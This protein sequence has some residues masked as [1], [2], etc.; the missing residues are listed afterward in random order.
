MARIRTL[1]PEFWADEKLARLSALTRLV[2]VGLISQAD[3]A[4]RLID[5]VKL[6]DGLL[7]PETD[8]T[9]R[10]ALEELAGADRILRYQSEAGQR[11]IQV[12][13]WEKHQKVDK[14]SKY[15][16]PAATET[17]APPPGNDPPPSRDSR[18]TVA[19]SPRSDLGPT[20]PDLR[21]TTSEPPRESAAEAPTPE[22]A[23]PAAAGDDGWRLHR[24]E[25]A[26]F[27]QG[28]GYGPAEL[29][30]AQGEDKSIWQTPTGDLVPWGD[31]LRLLGLADA[32]LKKSGTKA[33]DLRQALKYV[34]LQQ[35]DPIADRTAAEFAANRP[36]PGTEAA[37]VLA[38]TRDRDSGAGR[39]HQPHV[40]TGPQLVQVDPAE[41]GRE[42]REQRARR[43]AA[44]PA[45]QQQQLREEAR[46]KAGPQ[47][48]ADHVE[49]V[50]QG[51]ALK[52][53]S[54]AGNGARA[55]A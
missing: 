26:V 18:E 39:V 41:V 48:S 50:F 30:I 45:E 28:A 38:S 43:I 15:V 6:L 17:L 34:K 3:D 20:T 12:V 51:L 44:L 35:L 47:A 2:F 27:V 25:C 11:L 31:R 33:Q 24:D 19:R 21:P 29:L 7:F 36:Q 4:G 49:G 22:P 42:E 9:C 40:A 13:N 32:H 52:A 16:L 46:R 5:N 8:D 37:R 55:I 53:A 14:P 54:G 1:K 23:R 10:G